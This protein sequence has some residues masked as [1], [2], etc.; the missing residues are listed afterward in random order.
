MARTT[1]GYDD[2]TDDVRRVGEFLEW[3]GPLALCGIRD[4]KTGQLKYLEAS[5]RVGET[6]PGWLSGLNLCELIVQISLGEKLGPLPVDGFRSVRTHQTFLIVVSKALAGAGRL[7]ILRE[8][9]D[10]YRNR[11]VYRDSEDEL[12]R[13]REDWL[14]LVPAVAVILLMLANPKASHRL[15]RQTVEN[16]A[17]PASGA[18]LIH[19][20]SQERLL[21]CFG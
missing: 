6:V 14:S 10:V 13:P 21:E 17:L 4:Q 15:V 5:S 9:W 18:A 11:G 12:T 1:G 3:H 8:L 16:Y 19:S 20:F 7:D 2:R